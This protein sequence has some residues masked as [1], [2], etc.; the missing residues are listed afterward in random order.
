MAKKPRDP[1][2]AEAPD[3]SPKKSD[4][5]GLI[6]G[7]SKG[8]FLRVG[9]GQ[10]EKSKPK[11]K[12]PSLLYGDT[13]ATPTRPAVAEIVPLRRS[14]DL[15]TT[16][17]TLPG[18]SAKSADE[19]V[20]AL[21]SLA[22]AYLADERASWP[23]QPAVAP[24]TWT[25]H[26]KGN[27]DS[28]ATFTRAVYKRWIGKGFTRAWLYELDPPL[29]RALALYMSRHPD[30]DYA[31]LPDSN[32]DVDALLAR[33]GGLLTEDE[34]RRAGLAIEARRQRAKKRTEE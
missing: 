5:A 18:W 13:A 15:R 4:R 27:S 21:T 23:P 17:D 32:L 20:H 2:G 3:A 19:R 1:G 26:G 34:L 11:R 28:P 14:F 8:R 6:Y 30:E 12:T 16:L 9:D 10:A 7:Y 24:K 31:D 33:L 29:Y 25:E 22:S